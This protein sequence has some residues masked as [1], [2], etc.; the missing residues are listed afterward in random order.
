LILSTFQLAFGQKTTTHTADLN[1][2]KSL[3]AEIQ[4]SAGELKLAV[5]NQPKTEARFTYTRDAWKPQ[6]N[7]NQQTGQ[8]RLTI[9][10][11]EE[12]NI[13]MQDKDRNEWDIKLPQTPIEDMKVRM[14]AG[15]GSIDLRG[16]KVNRLEL[17]A[18]AGEFNVNLA[19]TSVAN[20]KVS[21]GVGELS[22]DLTGNRTTNLQAS[23]NGG[24]GD[25]HLVLPR[26]TGVRVKVNGLGSIENNGLRKQGGYYVN[27][28]YGKST[29]S[30]DI[31]VNGGLG[32]LDLKLEK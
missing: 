6:V 32:S 27:D 31:T 30:L 23:I 21:A 17:E 28:A 16:T 5:H 18:G 20:L 29:Q 11:P 14:G 25:M 15:K 8:G 10:Q 24:I 13:N 7:F 3:Q 12:K 26:K 1:G 4:M 2:V 22:L 19:K 9:R